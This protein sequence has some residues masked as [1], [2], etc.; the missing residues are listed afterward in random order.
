VRAGSFRTRPCPRLPVL[1][2]H[3]K[4]DQLTDLIDEAEEARDGVMN[5]LAMLDATSTMYE[6]KRAA[7]AG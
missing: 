4:I 1:F 7:A 3:W 6:E 2:K 5:Y